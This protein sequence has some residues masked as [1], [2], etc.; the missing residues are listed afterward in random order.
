MRTLRNYILAVIL[1]LGVG[2]IGGCGD[3]SPTGPSGPNPA[4][5]FEISNLRYDIDPRGYYASATVDYKGAEGGGVDAIYVR[6]GDGDC[7][8]WKRFHNTFYENKGPSGVYSSGPCH[9]STDGILEVYLQDNNK[10]DSNLLS[11]TVK[12]PGVP[13]H[14]FRS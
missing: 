1:I 14:G 10:R 12:N 8:D 9:F 11:T 3:K 2:V 7:K 6:G 5:G 13:T 4:P